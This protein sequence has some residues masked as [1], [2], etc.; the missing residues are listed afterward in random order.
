MDGRSLWTTHQGEVKGL[1][2]V[3]N[4]EEGGDL[5]RLGSRRAVFTSAMAAP[6]LGLDFL[7][8]KAGESPAFRQFSPRVA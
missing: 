8:A 2:A 7:G 4:D 3:A 5:W 6:G 1:E